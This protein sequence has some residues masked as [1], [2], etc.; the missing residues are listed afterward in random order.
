[1]MRMFYLYVI[2]D[3]SLKN[4]DGVVMYGGD[5]I[6]G[7]RFGGYVNRCREENPI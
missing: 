7:G 2:M 6:E 4:E 5:D 3:E 1:M